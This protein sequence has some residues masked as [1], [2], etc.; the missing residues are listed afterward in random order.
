MVLNGRTKRMQSILEY[1]IVLSA[2]IVGIILASGKIKDMVKS[3]L[4]SSAGDTYGGAQNS[5]KAK[6]VVDAPE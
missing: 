2:V 6:M 4:E 5:F 3:G 1:T